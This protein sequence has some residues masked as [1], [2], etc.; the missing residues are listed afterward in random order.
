M[1]PSL[2]YFGD[3]H[4]RARIAEFCGATEGRPPTAAYLTALGPAA[5]NGEPPDLARSLWDLEHLVFFLQLDFVNADH[6]DDPF[7]HPAD[8]LLKL[9]PAYRACRA[10]FD[11]FEIDLLSIATGRGYHFVGSD[12]ARCDRHR[13]ARLAGRRDAGL[14]RRPTRLDGRAASPPTITARHARAATGLGLL[15]EHAAHLILARSWTS[16]IPIRHQWHEGRHRPAGREC[17]SIDFAHVGE[18][19]DMVRVRTAFSPYRRHQYRPDLFGSKVSAIPPLVAL[20]RNER[21]LV[22]LLT[23]GRGLEVGR[24]AA[25]TARTAV[26]DVTGRHR[27]ADSAITCGRRWPRFI[28]SSSRSAAR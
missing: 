9:E 7:V 13:S 15:I 12:S 5:P 23:D 3:P 18:P 27:S 10:V 25:R 26:P 28:A 6:P 16:A 24:Q 8:V 1:P 2:R 19:L 21:P 14:A 11:E 4:V 22:T 17:V 20:P